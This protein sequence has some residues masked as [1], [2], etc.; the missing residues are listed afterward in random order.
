MP[1]PRPPVKRSAPLDQPPTKIIKK[2]KGNQTRISEWGDLL[3]PEPPQDA[4]VSRDSSPSSSIQMPNSIALRSNSPVR[5]NAFDR[6]E[7]SSH[8]GDDGLQDEVTQISSTQPSA[9][10]I[11]GM[12][13]Y[14][15]DFS[16]FPSYIYAVPTGRPRDGWIWKYGHDIQHLTE[17]KRGGKAKRRL[18]CK[19]CKRICVVQ[20]KSYN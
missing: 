6:L 18:V 11:T 7:A 5:D 12:R 17:K 1:K 15:M 19:I 16:K 2:P 9:P 13:D 8:Q 20:N 3:P 10:I 4:P 14:A